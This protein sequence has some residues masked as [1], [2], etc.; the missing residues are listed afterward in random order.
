MQMKVM[1]AGAM[2]LVGFLWSYLVMRQF[3][4]NVLVAYPVIKN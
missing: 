2:V 4:F 3:L 1:F